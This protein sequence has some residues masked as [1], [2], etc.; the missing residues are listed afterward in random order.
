M[1]KHLRGMTTSI[2]SFVEAGVMAAR[3][4][5]KQKAITLSN[6]STLAI[7]VSAVTGMYCLPMIFWSS[8]LSEL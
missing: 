5:Q 4:A 1:I 7:F 6:L 8:N 3:D 2:G